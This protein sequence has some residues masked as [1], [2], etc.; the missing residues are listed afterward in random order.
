MRT[1]VTDLLRQRRMRGHIIL[2]SPADHSSARATGDVI[3]VD[4]ERKTLIFT[5]TS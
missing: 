5:E 2:L 4:E 1:A 3:G